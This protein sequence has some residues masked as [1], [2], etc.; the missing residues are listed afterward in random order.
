[1]VTTI[2]SGGETVS[3]ASFGRYTKHHAAVAFEIAVAFWYAFCDITELLPELVD[4]VTLGFGGLDRRNYGIEV[5][6][7]VVAWKQ[8]AGLVLAI[9]DFL[10]HGAYQS[11]ASCEQALRL[12]H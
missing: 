9:V 1:M 5:V 12:G 8:Q 7:K 2:P 6:A 4:S 3:W 10:L 11:P